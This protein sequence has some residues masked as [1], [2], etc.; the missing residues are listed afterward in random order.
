MKTI[1]EDIKE[2]EK[3]K[4]SE[5]LTPKEIRIAKLAITQTMSEIG[6]IRP[7]EEQKEFLLGLALDEAAHHVFHIY[8]RSIDRWQAIFNKLVKLQPEKVLDRRDFMIASVAA[9]KISLRQVNKIEEDELANWFDL[10]IDLTY[11]D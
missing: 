9:I 7:K 10:T 1:I 8:L 4:F 3:V 5:S 2:I 11:S 6:V